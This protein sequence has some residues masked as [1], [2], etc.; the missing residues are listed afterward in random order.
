[1]KTREGQAFPRVRA[2]DDQALVAVAVAS[3]GPGI[4]GLGRLQ[5]WVT[6]PPRVQMS[7]G[8]WPAGLVGT[9]F[10][11]KAYLCPPLPC[12]CPHQVFCL[13]WSLLSTDP[14]L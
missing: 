14:T 7:A 10:A 1:M 13:R 12:L 11:N 4:P 3:H 5:G 8:V 2:Q 6:E 9:D